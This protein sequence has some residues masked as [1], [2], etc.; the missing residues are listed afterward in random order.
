MRLMLVCIAGLA[1]LASPLAAEEEIKVPSGQKVTIIDVV[2]DTQG[3]A[4]LT[5]RFR[6]LA[7][8]IARQGGTVGA[9]AAEA[10]MQALCDGYAL[11]RLPSTGPKPEEIVISL[12]DRPVAFGE[13][14]PDATQYFEAYRP[15]GKSCVWEAF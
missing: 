3:P 12:S 6:F 2:Q 11:A 14:D 13:P 4:G 1:G 7:P 9:D 10:D 15:D 5:Y 8:A